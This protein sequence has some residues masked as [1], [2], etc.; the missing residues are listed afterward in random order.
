MVG[1]FL[2]SPAAAAVSAFA[3]ILGAG[4]SAVHVPARRLRR[5][6][7]FLENLGGDT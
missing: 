1:T 2:V 4:I 5:V 6:S 7:D 3:M